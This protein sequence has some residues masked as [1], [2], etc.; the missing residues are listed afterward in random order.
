MENIINKIIDIDRMAE[1]RL[2]DA[3][4]ES[5]NLIAKSERE[6][7]DLKENLRSAAEKRISEVRDFHKN[8]TE[9]ELNRIRSEC[10]AKIKELD[11]AYENK[12]FSIEESIYRTIVGESVE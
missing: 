11:E 5:Q 1:K 6:A 9:A 7:A 8:E 3:E 2:S 10:D 4:T 12:H